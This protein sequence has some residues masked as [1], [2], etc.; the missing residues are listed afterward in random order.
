MPYEPKRRLTLC[1]LFSEALKILIVHHER[2]PSLYRVSDLARHHR[3]STMYGYGIAPVWSR[4]DYSLF[5]M[6]EGAKP[7]TVPTLVLFV[8]SIPAPSSTDQAPSCTLRKQGQPLTNEG[9]FPLLVTISLPRAP[10][11]SLT[12]VRTGTSGVGLY[13]IYVRRMTVFSVVCTLFTLPHLLMCFFGDSLTRAEMD[14]L[15]LL[16]FA[17]GNHRCVGQELTL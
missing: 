3:T 14:P 12:L 2:P 7:S 11:L 10:Y 13:F 9:V 15:R 6:G 4:N 17:A 5:Q 8:V 16:T 1:V